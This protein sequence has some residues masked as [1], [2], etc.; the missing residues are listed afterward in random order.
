MTFELS[1]HAI[2]RYRE[3]VRPAL[4]MGAARRELLA[5]LQ[6]AEHTNVKPDW[7][8]VDD[9]DAYPGG[10]L[11]AC[12]SVAFPIRDGII[13][14]C[15]TRGSLNPRHRTA[16]NEGK[17]RR[18]MFRRMDRINDARPSPKRTPSALFARTDPGPTVE[19]NDEAAAPLERPAA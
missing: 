8:E 7:V 5:V 11:I 16:R 19:D 14:T 1:S 10:W 3:R 6:A 13:T 15:L 12:D 2:L 17:R 18:R 4:A 9:P